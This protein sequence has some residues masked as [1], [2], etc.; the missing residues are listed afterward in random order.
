MTTESIVPSAIAKLRTLRTL[1]SEVQLPKLY[2]ALSKPWATG[3]SHT[4]SLRL[5]PAEIMRFMP[6]TCK[7][8]RV[9]ASW[10]KK[11][12]KLEIRCTCQVPVDHD[13]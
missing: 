3:T 6:D 12:T 5:V 13:T 2:D 11:F 8:A 4:F 9:E 10:R 1:L 7:L